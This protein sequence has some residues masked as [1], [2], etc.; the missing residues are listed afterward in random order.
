MKTVMELMG[1]HRRIPYCRGKYG[2]EIEVEGSNLPTPKKYWRVEHDG[3]L[4]G[5]SCE[6][7]MAVPRSLNGTITSIKSLKHAFKLSGGSINKSNRTGVHV[8]V[9]VQKLTAKELFTFITA[10]LVLEDLL[11]DWCGKYRVGNLFCL[12]TKDADYFYEYLS[13]VMGHKELVALGNDDIRYCS[14]NLASLRKYGSVE[15]R[16]MRG[17]SNLDDVIDWVKIVDRV[18]T[19]SLEEFNDPR[20]VIEAMSFSSPKEFIQRLLGDL[21]GALLGIP[22]VEEKVWGGVRR[23]QEVAYGH[24][25]STEFA[26][27]YHYEEYEE[28]DDEEGNEEWEE[29][30]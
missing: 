3:S 21:S 24:D 27:S 12:R 14:I 19:R 2:V 16:A 7:V 22:K 26:P 20:T 10:Y 28:E 18:F 29:E 30:W 25:W 5:Q 8:H 17:S 1:L 9:N 13:G 6:Y 4:R 11:V 23:A 15:L